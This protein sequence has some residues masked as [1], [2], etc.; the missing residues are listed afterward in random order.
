MNILKFN[1]NIK[2]KQLNKKPPKTWLMVG[3]G[4]KEGRKK[5]ENETKV[6]KKEGRNLNSGAHLLSTPFK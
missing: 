6:G 1:Q 5:G 3:K 4:R 2:S